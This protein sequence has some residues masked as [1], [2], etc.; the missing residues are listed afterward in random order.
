M[1]SVISPTEG[2][3]CELVFA[4]PEQPG[5]Y[6]ACPSSW[7]KGSRLSLAR[8]ITGAMT[9]RRTDQRWFLQQLHNRPQRFKMKRRHRAGAA[10]SAGPGRRLP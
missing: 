1:G 5:T 3:T 9:Q 4:E 10:I 6:G 8:S 7:E 2:W